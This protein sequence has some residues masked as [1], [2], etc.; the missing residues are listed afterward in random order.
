MISLNRSANI[1]K[2]SNKRDDTRH[3]LLNVP[4]INAM[5]ET[6]N[7]IPGFR[8]EALKVRNVDRCGACMVTLVMTSNWRDNLLWKISTY[9]SPRMTFWYKSMYTVHRDTWRTLDKLQDIDN[10]WGKIRIVIPWRECDICSNDQ[11]F[12]YTLEGKLSSYLGHWVH[13][14]T[15]PTRDSA[16]GLS[17]DADLVLYFDMVSWP[18]IVLATFPIF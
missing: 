9:H 6:G 10:H 13:G 2:Q 16:D 18:T 4:G 3:I 7:S 15:L 5:T 12:H 14:L 8:Q 17:I 11:R 1:D